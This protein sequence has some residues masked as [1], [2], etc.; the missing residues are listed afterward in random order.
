VG[1]L[2]TAGYQEK[3]K[4]VSTPIAI[5]CPN[6]A[7]FRVASQG[8]GQNSKFCFLDVLF[9]DPYNIPAKFNE[10][11]PRGV[12]ALRFENVDITQTQRRTD[13]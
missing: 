1:H 9:N 3:V 6:R 10:L 12:G 2:W 13:I 11:R 8:T 5:I 7:K 4:K